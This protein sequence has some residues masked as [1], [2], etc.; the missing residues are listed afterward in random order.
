[1]FVSACCLRFEGLALGLLLS[2]GREAKENKF[3]IFFVAKS[4]TKL[5]SWLAE[6]PGGAFGASRRPRV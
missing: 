4:P 6:G 3:F 2:A 5:R 1:M